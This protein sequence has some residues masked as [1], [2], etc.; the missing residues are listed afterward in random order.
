MGTIP[1]SSYLGNLRRVLQVPAG[2]NGILRGI[3]VD[4][5]KRCTEIFQKIIDIF[6]PD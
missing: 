3:P 4:A 2:I 5:V 6:Q 1:Q